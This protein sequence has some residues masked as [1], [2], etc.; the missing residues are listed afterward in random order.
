MNTARNGALF[1]GLLLLAAVAF[2]AALATGSADVSLGESVNA[3]RGTGPEH[4]RKI[5]ALIG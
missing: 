5:A 4:I 1:A 3:L 2:T